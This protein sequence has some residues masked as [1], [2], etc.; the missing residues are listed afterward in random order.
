M[1]DISCL[2]IYDTSS[3]PYSPYG[4]F[5]TQRLLRHTGLLSFFACAYHRIIL[6]HD[7][8]ISQELND[9]WAVIRECFSISW[10]I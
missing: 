1:N 10:W 2:C 6:E 8:K 5:L 3:L 4:I 7:R 9:I